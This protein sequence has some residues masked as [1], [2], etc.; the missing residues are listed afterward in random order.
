MR[1]S[2]ILPGDFFSGTPPSCLVFRSVRFWIVSGL[3]LGGWSFGFFRGA[4]TA[5]VAGCP[6][7]IDTPP[8]PYYDGRVWKSLLLIRTFISCFAVSCT[9]DLHIT[10]YIIRVVMID[11]RHV[12]TRSSR[13]GHRLH[14]DV[15]VRDVLLRPCRRDGKGGVMN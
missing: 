9:C 14:T 7:P 15:R 6:A 12:I 8:P 5:A 3:T 1:L 13:E 10:P 11:V 2:V 4:W